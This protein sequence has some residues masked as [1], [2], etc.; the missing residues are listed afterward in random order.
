MLINIFILKRFVV[1][2]KIVNLNQII[3]LK[4]KYKKD[5]YNQEPYA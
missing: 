1:I 3:F 4:S 2:I 5:Y